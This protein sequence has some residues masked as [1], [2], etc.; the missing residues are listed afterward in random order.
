MSHDVLTNYEQWLQT[1]ELGF[2]TELYHSKHFYRKIFSLFMAFKY[3]FVT[4]KSIWDINS[5]EIS[6][7]TYKHL[8]QIHFYPNNLT[9]TCKKKD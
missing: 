7:I 1:K 2:F 6:N 5:K 3:G 4:R 8:L 9:V